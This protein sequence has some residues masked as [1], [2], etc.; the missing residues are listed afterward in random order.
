MNT[1]GRL[2]KI[3]RDVPDFPK[4]G[5][6]FKD[7][8]T[9]LQDPKGFKQSVNLLYKQYKGEKIDYIVC[10]EAR[11]FIFGSALAYKL[12]AGLVLIRKKG[13]LPYKT[14]SVTYALEYGED[15]LE[16]HQDAIR[17]NGR[18]LII[19]DLLATGGTIQAVCK[20]LNKCKAKIVGI[21]FFIELLF[22]RGRKK[23]QKYPISSIIK[24]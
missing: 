8:T 10:V 6:L 23:L 11:G 9:V 2:A 18:V 15:T 24:Y 19:D 7:I 13:K 17:E 20:L 3:I 14:Y 4:K 1:V 5:I 12:N 22:L 21:G 16:I